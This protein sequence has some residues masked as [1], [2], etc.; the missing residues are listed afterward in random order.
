MPLSEGGAVIPPLLASEGDRRKSGLT[1]APVPWVPNLK[2]QKDNHILWYPDYLYA[3]S[4]SSLISR[5]DHDE[6]DN[7]DPD[8]SDF[9]AF[10]L[11]QPQYLPANWLSEIKADDTE[12]NHFAAENYSAL[13]SAY[14][15]HERLLRWITKNESKDSNNPVKFNDSLAVHC[16][17]CCGPA[18]KIWRMSI[19]PMKT[20][21]NLEPIRYDMQR[22][23]TLDL[24]QRNG[25][26]RLC[27]WINTLNA[28][29]LTVQFKDIIADVKEALANRTNPT[30]NVRYSFSW[31]SKI[32]FVY[33]PG[34]ETEL[35]AA[36]LQDLRDAYNHGEIIAEE[37]IGKT[38][39]QEW[40]EA[41]RA[42]EV[43][44]SSQITRKKRQ[45]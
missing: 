33:V 35:R 21:L 31:T 17:T 16:I 45:R 29:A 39:V 4:A 3:V 36:P 2:Q 44:V 9:P 12:S 13:M 28:L 32:G 37:R 42:I 27:D 34:S 19:R 20:S 25:I 11:A 10:R 23:A 15:L 7:E 30:S 22:L 24:E 38:V 26:Q 41:G 6:D 14:L 18:C 5:L 1:V 40:D 8:L 43:T